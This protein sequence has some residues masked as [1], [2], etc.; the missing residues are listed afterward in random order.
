MRQSECA[1][2]V[3]CGGNC[4]QTTPV[5]PVDG[6]L[7]EPCWC[8]AGAGHGRQEER[9]EE[10]VVQERR[11]EGTQE[12]GAATASKTGE[13]LSGLELVLG[14]IQK[15]QGSVSAQAGM[16]IWGK[17]KP[18]VNAPAPK[19]GAG[20][21]SS[22]DAGLPGQAGNSPCPDPPPHFFHSRK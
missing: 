4:F 18:S 17:K 16:R 3:S 10:G 8:L 15:V 22:S 5:D 9:Q 7:K 20:D 12:G 2:H 19:T 13:E 14:A 11:G 1:R 21:G 6:N